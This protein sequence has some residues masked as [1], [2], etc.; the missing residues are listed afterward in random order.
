MGFSTKLSY[1]YTMILWTNIAFWLVLLGLGILRFYH[2]VIN[3][4]HISVNYAGLS[5]YIVFLGL[6]IFGLLIPLISINTSS[7]WH[8]T[9]P[10]WLQVIGVL[11]LLLLIVCFYQTLIQLDKQ[12]SPTL[13]IKTDHTLITTGIYQYVRHPMYACGS[14]MIITHALLVPNIISLVSLCMAMMVLIIIRIPNE[15]NMLQRQFGEQY[16]IYK[17][18]T[19]A[20]IPLMCHLWR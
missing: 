16:Q 9:I 12:D 11:L 20:L 10:L 8:Y 3:S 4:D 6:V 17:H 13:Q 2:Y 7:T 14:I 19:C 18:D 1:I 15:E 5:E